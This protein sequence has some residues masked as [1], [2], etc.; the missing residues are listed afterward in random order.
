MWTYLVIAKT[1]GTADRVTYPARL[2]LS[3]VVTEATLSTV[4]DMI[5]RGGL[6]QLPWMSALENA[7]IPLTDKGG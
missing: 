5:L 7:C 6:A 1:V 3:S 2:K 4:A